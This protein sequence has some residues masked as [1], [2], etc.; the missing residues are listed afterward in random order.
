MTGKVVSIVR[1]DGGWHA[2][3]DTRAAWAFYVEWRDVRD[4][5]LHAELFIRTESAREIEAEY[6]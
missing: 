3:A 1:V 6:A 2:F 4:C 5:E